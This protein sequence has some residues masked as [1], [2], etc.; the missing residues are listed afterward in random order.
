MTPTPS[1][2]P[3]RRVLLRASVFTALLGALLFPMLATAPAALAQPDC[4]FRGELDANYCDA[5]KDLVADTPTDPKRLRTP[6]TIV[7][8]YTP[9]E[10]PAVY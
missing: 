3:L 2:G 5:N 4:P 10:D 7:F 8:T 9:V 6:N 1:A